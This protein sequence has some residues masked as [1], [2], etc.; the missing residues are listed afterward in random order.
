[1]NI[2]SLF[3]RVCQN[4]G[5]VIPRMPVEPVTNTINR[6]MHYICNRSNLCNLSNTNKINTPTLLQPSLLM[7]NLT[8]GLKMKTVLQRRCKSCLL[9]WKNDRK[10]II[11]KDRPRHNQVQRKKKSYNTWI[12]THATQGRV[13]EW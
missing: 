11:C 2:S 1:M 8:C 9:M 5:S 7:Y 6:K 12:L 3:R 4:I 13:R 10:Y